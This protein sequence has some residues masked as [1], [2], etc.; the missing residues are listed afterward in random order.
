[1]NCCILKKR[2]YIY[3]WYN[4][5]LIDLVSNHK[6]KLPFYSCGPNGL[7]LPTSP[8]HMH[9][10]Y[11]RARISLL[12]G[13]RRKLLPDTSSGAY[14][15]GEQKNRAL[16]F[17]IPDIICRGEG[18]VGT[19]HRLKILVLSC[20][21][22]QV[23]TTLQCMGVL[24]LRCKNVDS[25]ITRTAIQS[26]LH[27]ASSTNM[28]PTTYLYLDPGHPVWTPSWAWR[29]GGVGQEQACCTSPGERKK[30]EK[31]QESNCW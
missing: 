30:E 23:R 3:G 7:F 26:D 14:L 18:R 6:V 21:N 9:G 17:N 25:I 28:R 19:P 15:Q 27:A 4:G 24:T 29:V 12:R 1:M 8:I 31:R 13:G 22:W 20:C 5:C 10:W 2:I 11:G 16:N